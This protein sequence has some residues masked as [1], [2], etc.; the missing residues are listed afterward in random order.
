MA[1]YLYQA[2]SIAS[3]RLV[4]GQADAESALELAEKLRQAG[5][6]PLSVHAQGRLLGVLR[7]LKQ[8]EP[9]GPKELA[10]L[11]RQLATMLHAGLPLVMALEVIGGQERGRVQVVARAIHQGIVRGSSLADSIG[12][13]GVPFPEMHVNLIRAGELS[14]NLDQVLD[15]LATMQEKELAVRG[16]VRS[17]TIYPLV[18]LLVAIGV[19]TFMLLVV[20]PT[21]VGIFEELNAELPLLTRGILS[22]VRV[23]QRWWYIVLAAVVA[24]ALGAGRVSRTSSGRRVV[25][26]WKL[27][28]PVFGRLNNY[29][30]LGSMGRTL[31]MLLGSGIPLM[32]V[33]E[34]AGDSLG[35]AVYRRALE[36]VKQ[37]VSKGE[38]LAD[39][40]RWTGIIPPFV[41]EMVRIGEQ[42]GALE[43]MMQKIA[44]HYDRQAEEMVANL[45][46]LLE[47]AMLVLIGG[48][49]ATV[50]VSL[51]LPILTLLNAVETGI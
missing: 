25:D 14:G 8:L 4:R 39:T 16:K 20:V 21:F 30:L 26:S 40:M 33:L 12:R 43:P 38:T 50:L 41:V 2:R 18:V 22:V 3:G 6:V 51:L 28:V 36:E 44:E 19:L 29:L 42:A 15:R 31:A 46:A 7:R 1:V 5:Y 9:M 10:L 34:A 47:P 35:N 37:G 49:V 32:Q 24:L 48:V 13:S 27:R 17:A 45:T 23:V 11:Y